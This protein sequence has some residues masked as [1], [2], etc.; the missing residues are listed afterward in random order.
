MRYKKQAKFRVFRIKL[1]SP[2]ENRHHEASKMSVMFTKK[3]YVINSL[4]K[5][6]ILASIMMEN[7]VLFLCS[8]TSL[9]FYIIQPPL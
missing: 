7:A 3:H 1:Q 5:D 4:K 2:P 8:F 9:R 6:R